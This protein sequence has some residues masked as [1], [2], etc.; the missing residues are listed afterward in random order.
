[1][2][3]VLGTL[4]YF[5]F[6]ATSLAF[7]FLLSPEVLLLELDSLPALA[8]AGCCADEDDDPERPPTGRPS[9]PLS[10]DGFEDEYRRFWLRR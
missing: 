7:R 9:E 5:A 8:S 4:G 10:R 3:S 1:M 6:S 2:C